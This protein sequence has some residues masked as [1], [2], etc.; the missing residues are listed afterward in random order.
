[1]N[2]NTFSQYLS[3]S[4]VISHVG[5]D[6]WSLR[7]S[8]VDPAAVE[9]LREANAARLYER[10]IIDHCRTAGDLWLAARLP[11]QPWHFVVGIP[12]A[13]RRYVIGR[14]FPATDENGLAAGTV[15]VNE[16]GAAYGYG[17][18]LVRRGADA[19]DILLISFRITKNL[20]TLQL[21]DDEALEAIS[22]V[23]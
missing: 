9:A 8:R 10:R 18:F 23:A 5:L 20:S 19:G 15:R 4:P 17:R 12:S 16:E 11:D 6:M 22:L 14:E 2:A 13:L 3:S 21:I 7:G 1:M